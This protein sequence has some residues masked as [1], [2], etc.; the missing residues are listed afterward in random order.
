MAL[1]VWRM[2]NLFRRSQLFE[3]A[4][5]SEKEQAQVTLHAIG[6]AVIRVNAAGSVDY[7]NA[8]AER[9]LGMSERQAFGLPLS[10]IAA[11]VDTACGETRCQIESLLKGDDAPYATSELTLLTAA[12]PTPVSVQTAPFEVAGMTAGTVLVLRDITRERGLIARLQWQ[13][14]HDELTGLANRR[15]LDSRLRARMADIDAESRDDALMLLD[16][17]QFKLVNDTCGHAA[18]DQLL[19]EVATLLK[20]ELDKGCLPV[21]L[22]GDEFA[23]ILQDCGLVRA[24]E[25]AERLRGAIQDLNFVWED[26]LFKIAASIGLVT[27][28]GALPNVDD[29]LRAADVACYM[30][31]DKGRNRVHVHEP[32]DVEMLKRVSE[33]GW[34][35]RLRDALDEGRLRLYAQRIA[36]LQI[37]TDE[38]H[39]ELLVRLIDESGAVVPPGSFIPAAERFGLM[40]LIDRWVVNAAF[41]SLAEQVA[42]C[43]GGETHLSFA[44]NLSGQSLGDPAFVAFVRSMFQTH[45]VSPASIIF[46]ITE[47]AAI[48]NLHEATKFIQIFRDIGCKFALDDFGAGMSSFGYLKRLAVDYLKIDGGFV[49]DILVDPMDHAMVDTIARMAR[50]L[51]KQTI[52]EFAESDEIIDALREMSV[53]Y[54]QGYGISRPAPLAEE[55]AWASSNRPAAEPAREWSALAQR[56]A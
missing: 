12:G 6:D 52:A 1:V 40:P 26:R 47:T 3:S 19:R 7:A 8:A 39:F 10:S 13:A 11:I 23:V 9:L 17:D 49:K 38:K 14:S 29:A 4:L 25:I 51:G 28:V 18:G 46:E 44:R 33:M 30:A 37:E 24:T 54:A 41:A 16:L 50:K 48:A 21:R 35:H 32:T 22:G 55:L 31:K 43:G 36:P 56:C 45:L 5:S 15:E 34:V 42:A 27:N 20:L 53:D 2:R